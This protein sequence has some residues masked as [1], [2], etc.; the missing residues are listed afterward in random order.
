[1]VQRHDRRVAQPAFEI[2]DVLLRHACRL[3][4]ALLSE[5]LLPPQPRK[6][7]AH[8]PAHVHARKGGRL[9]TFGFISYNMY[10]PGRDYAVK[11]IRED[12]VAIR[13]MCIAITGPVLWSDRGPI[14]LRV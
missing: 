8:Q 2:A 13:G 4:E 9:H 1:M 5:A 11:H 14:S 3:G 6:I 7:P 10:S 12:V